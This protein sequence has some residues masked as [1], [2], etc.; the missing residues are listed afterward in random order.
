MP[1]RER[2]PSRSARSTRRSSG[3][4]SAAR[5]TTGTPAATSTAKEVKRLDRFTQFALVAGDR[6]R[7]RLGHRLRQG[8]SVPLRRD[9]GSGIGGLNEIEVQHQRLLNK[10]PDKV[11]AFTIPKLMLQ[12]GQRQALDPLRA[13]RA[14]TRGGHRLRQRHQRHRRRLQDDPVRRRRRDDHRRQRSGGDAHG[15]ERLSAHAGPLR[16]QRRSAAGQPPL[17]PRPRRLRAQPR[18]PGCWSSRNSSTPR[19]AVRGSTPRC[20]GY[21]VS[22]DGGHITQPDKDGTGAAYA[23][24]QALQRRRLEPGRDR[25]HQRP[26]HQHAAGRQ[27][28]DHGHQD[29]SSAT[30]PAS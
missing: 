18:A 7:A 30:T 13:S 5:S 25:L 22:G 6:R 26:R 23:M 19:P 1:R 9:L 2:S 27:G 10:G 21:G 29:A 16:A 4:S 15:P 17:R 11:S 8:R 14:R 24:A 3:S 20:C 28:R 12:R